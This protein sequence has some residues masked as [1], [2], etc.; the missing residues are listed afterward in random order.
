MCLVYF[1]WKKYVCLNGGGGEEVIIINWYFFIDF[2][3]ILGRLKLLNK[4]KKICL[5]LKL[6]IW[7][8]F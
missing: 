8:K 6:I 5:Y 4:M 3:G 1:N 2:E 7:F